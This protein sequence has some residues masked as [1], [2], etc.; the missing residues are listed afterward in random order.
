[1]AQPSIACY[2][3]NRKRAAVDDVKI[4]QARK[5]L[6]LD[7]SDDPTPVKQGLET[8]QGIIFAQVSKSLAKIEDEAAS[9]K[10]D[11]LQK[12]EEKMLE[13][14]IISLPKTHEPVS[15]KKVIKAIRSRKIKP[16]SN[17]TDIQKLLTK[18]KYSETSEKVEEMEKTPPSTPTKRL[19]AMDNVS[20]DGPSIKEL[21]NKMSRSSRLAKLKNSLAKF[22]ENDKKLTIIEQKTVQIESPKLKSFKTIE[23]E[24]TT[25]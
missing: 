3:N 25:R 6:V 17:S 13:S 14:K 23:L 10:V 12:N 2:F 4:N 7:R 21:R 8:E 22:E 19:N 16:V 15:P 1:M 18:M 11:I 9:E 20:G 24:V 5:V